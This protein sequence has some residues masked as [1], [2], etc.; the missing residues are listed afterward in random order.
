MLHHRRLCKKRPHDS[1]PFGERGRLA[2][3]HGVVFQRVP[4]NHQEVA[5]RTLDAAVDF[6]A[7][8]AFGLRDDGA[9]AALNGGFKVGRAGGV[10]EY[11]DTADT[12]WHAGGGDTWDERRLNDRSIGLEFEVRC[13]PWKGRAR[14]PLNDWTPAML[15]AGA[16][17]TAILCAKFWI[18]ANRVHIVGHSEVPGAT[19]TDPGP[20]FPWDTFMA[21]VV[22]QMGA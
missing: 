15:D 1:A 9:G 13:N 11:V 17:V 19:H 4:I 16:E 21:A 20:A 22:A 7:L 5:A 2:K 3:A 12:A 18:P 10:A 14:F 6:V 8:E